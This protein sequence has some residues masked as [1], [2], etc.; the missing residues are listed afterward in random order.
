MNHTLNH[1][2]NYTIDEEPHRVS[3]ID[4]NGIEI[5][6]AYEL[7]KQHCW[8]LYVTTLVEQAAHMPTPP[9]HEHFWGEHGRVDAQA[10]V[11]LIAALYVAAHE[12]AA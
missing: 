6:G 5:A 7:E 8:N 9:H 2:V 1:T 11:E 3:A 10:W 4:Q 12:R